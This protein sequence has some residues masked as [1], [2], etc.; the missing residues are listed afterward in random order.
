MLKKEQAQF[1]LFEGAL[2]T[3]RAQRTLV[4]IPAILPRGHVIFEPTGR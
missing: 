4:H 2:E 3:A 1:A